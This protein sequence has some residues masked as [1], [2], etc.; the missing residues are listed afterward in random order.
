MQRE[1]WGRLRDDAE[2]ELKNSDKREPPRVD[3]FGFH[4]PVEYVERTAMLLKLSDF[5]CW[6]ES[7]GWADQD[8]FL[9]D[10]VMR[11]FGLRARVMW[12]L[13]YQ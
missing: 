4:H 13:K 1:V 9:V 2:R 6:P 5:V 8:D 11:W 3:D 10:D 12:E 7:G